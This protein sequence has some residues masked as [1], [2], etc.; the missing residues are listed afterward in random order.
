MRFFYKKGR[1]Y[2]DLRGNLILS[3]ND[4]LIEAPA[5]SA[6]PYTKNGTYVM[7]KKLSFRQKIT[8]TYIAIAF[9]WSH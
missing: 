6:A 4:N 5:K 3:K 7:I 1:R 9:I 8:A 2:L